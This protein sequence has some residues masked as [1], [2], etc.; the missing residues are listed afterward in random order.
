MTADPGPEDGLAPALRLM[1]EI[2]L[3]LEKE[4]TRFLVAA[5]EDRERMAVLRAAYELIAAAGLQRR[6][7]EIAQDRHDARRGAVQRLEVVLN[8]LGERGVAPFD[9]FEANPDTRLLERAPDMP[10]ELAPFLALGL[11]ISC[12]PDEL[13]LRRLCDR[14]PPADAASL[15][16]LGERLES[17]P[18]LGDLVVD[19]TGKHWQTTDCDVIQSVLGMLDYLGYRW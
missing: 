5:L 14:L 13:V 10:Q 9:G 15:H 6:L 1:D 3:P 17:D 2:R 11:R 18:K 19:W 16:E 4:F 12:P 7:V 8:L